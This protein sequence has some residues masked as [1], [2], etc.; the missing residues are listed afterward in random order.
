MGRDTY[1]IS[2]LYRAF[3]FGRALAFQNRTAQTSMLRVEFEL[4]IQLSWWSNTV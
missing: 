2:E 3:V 1:L 4:M